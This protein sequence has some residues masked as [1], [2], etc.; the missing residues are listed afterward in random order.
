MRKKNSNKTNWRSLGVFAVCLALIF[1]LF[2]IVV[3]GILSKQRNTTSWPSVQG[4]IIV[5]EIEHRYNEHADRVDERDEYR[6]DFMYQYVIESETYE[7]SDIYFLSGIGSYWDHELNSY[8]YSLL[9]NYPVGSN[10]TV[11]YNPENPEQSCLITGEDPDTRLLIILLPVVGYILL[12]CF[13]LFYFMDKLAKK[14]KSKKKEY[15]SFTQPE[16]IDKIK[17]ASE[18]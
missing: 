7:S 4:I 18:S 5:C 16:L 3:F 11:H 17:K 13:P 10:V 12:G 8:E 2:P 6:I 15:K 9:Q 14:R 1:A